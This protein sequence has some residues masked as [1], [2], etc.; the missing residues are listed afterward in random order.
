MDTAVTETYAKYTQTDFVEPQVGIDPE[1]VR[2]RRIFRQKI[3]IL[4][5]E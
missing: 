2:S 5:G 1:A 3:T 4:L